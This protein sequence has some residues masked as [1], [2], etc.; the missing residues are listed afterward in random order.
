M[1]HNVFLTAVT[2]RRFKP[3]VNLLKQLFCKLQDKISKFIE[4]YLM[5]N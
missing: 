5:Q 3:Q 4:R 1:F 2:L